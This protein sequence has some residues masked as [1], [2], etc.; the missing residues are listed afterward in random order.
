[1]NNIIDFFADVDEQ[2]VCPSCGSAEFHLWASGDV[3]CAVCPQQVIIND[4]E[5]K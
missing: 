2:L 3:W 5:E 4:A 1:M